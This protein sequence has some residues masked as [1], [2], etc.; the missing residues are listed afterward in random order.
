MTSVIIRWRNRSYICFRCRQLIQTGAHSRRLSPFFL[1]TLPFLFSP[2]APTSQS[3][4]LQHIAVSIMANLCGS[5]FFLYKICKHSLQK[6][7]MMIATDVKA[8]MFRQY[9]T[10]LILKSWYVVK[11]LKKCISFYVT[12]PCFIL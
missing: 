10:A 9:C 3:T 4:H 11:Y 1:Q 7:N 8:K 2:Y 6:H 5:P 12:N